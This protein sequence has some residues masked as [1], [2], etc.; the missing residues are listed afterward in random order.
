MKVKEIKEKILPALDDEFAK[1]VGEFQTLADLKARLRKTLEEQKQAQADQAVKEKLLDL[2]REKHPF[3]IPQSMIDRQVEHIMA[4]TELAAG[5]AGLE[6]EHRRPG[7]PEDPRISH[8]ERRK[9]K[10]GEA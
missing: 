1:E 6:T 3:A 8:P 2:L 7:Q 4:R 5:Q 9:K 10:C